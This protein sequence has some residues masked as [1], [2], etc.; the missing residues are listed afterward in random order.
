MSIDI[1]V[2]GDVHELEISE[3]LMPLFNAVVEG[4]KIASIICM[5]SRIARD[6]PEEDNTIKGFVAEMYSIAAMGPSCD[7]AKGTCDS[8]EAAFYMHLVRD[9]EL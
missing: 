4:K 1:D 7:Y 3:R 8:G 6:K 2:Y 9:F 5:S